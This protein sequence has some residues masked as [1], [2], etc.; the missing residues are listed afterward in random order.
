MVPLA[1]TI[2]CSHLTSSNK[3][4]IMIVLRLARMGRKNKATFRL[5]AQD[6][7]RAPN[8]RSLEIVGSYNPHAKTR[9][10]QIHLNT[11]RIQHW[12][13]H[14]AQPSATV[15]NMLVELGII[16]APKRR[17]VR[18][19][20]KKEEAAPEAKPKTETPVVET[21]QEV[22]KQPEKQAAQEK[23]TE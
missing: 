10:E 21:P 22:P 9:E 19:K 18:G 14:G 13:Q 15:H 17:V 8:S 23:A 4:F 16:Q 11:E 2:A 7:R 5:V 12:L 3:F 1:P 6:K 20:A